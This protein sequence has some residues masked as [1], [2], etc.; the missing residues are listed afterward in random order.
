[1]K[2]I[3]SV[4]GAII[5]FMAIVAQIPYMFIGGMIMGFS[6]EKYFGSRITLNIWVPTVGLY[7][8]WFDEYERVISREISYK[9]LFS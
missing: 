8:Y 1:M 2:A 5:D 4:F 3:I 7:E 6:Y 9:Q